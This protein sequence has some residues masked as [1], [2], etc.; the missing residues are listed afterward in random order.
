MSITCHVV[1]DGIGIPDDKLGVVFM[2]FGQASIGSTREYGG[3]G[4]GLAITSNIMHA[5][6]GS[7]ECA[8]T[9]GRGTT[10]TLKLS[11]EIAGAGG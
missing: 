5:L 2:P 8:S 6:G 3:T 1:D 9:L 4:L 11:L 7:I 10:M